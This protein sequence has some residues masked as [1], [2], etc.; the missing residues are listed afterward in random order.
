MK[1]KKVTVLLG[2][3][4]LVA[5]LLFAWAVINA[6]AD[7]AGSTGRDNACVPNG[8]LH[9]VYEYV[10]YTFPIVDAWY[11]SQG[12]PIGTPICKQEEWFADSCDAKIRLISGG[13]SNLHPCP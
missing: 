1:A 3:G 4:L 10:P 8:T 12:I 5:G 9:V 13:V 6:K 2:V 7:S 11:E